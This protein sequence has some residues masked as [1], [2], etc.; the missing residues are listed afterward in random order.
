[1][2]SFQ[3]LLSHV[4]SALRIEEIF[5]VRVKCL[6]NIILRY[7]YSNALSKRSNY[8]AAPYATLSILL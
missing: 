3:D 4:I 8:E 1:M 6:S 7:N 5:I 2:N